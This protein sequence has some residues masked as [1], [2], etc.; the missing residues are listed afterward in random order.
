MKILLLKLFESTLTGIKEIF[1]NKT[2]SFL[3]MLGITLGVAS[4]ITMASIVEGAKISTI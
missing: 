2:R 3:T 4:L 1:Y